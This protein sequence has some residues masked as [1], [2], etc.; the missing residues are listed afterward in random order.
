[1]D[2]PAS[3]A[4]P[5]RWCLLLRCL[6]AACGAGAGSPAGVGCA[7][8]VRRVAWV[9]ACPLALAAALPGRC[10]RRGYWPA[11]A[12]SCAAWALRVARVLA[13]LLAWAA[14]P[15]CA[16]W[17]G[18]WPACWRWL[19]RCLGA[20]CGVGTGLLALAPALPGRC[21]WCGCWLLRCR[22]AAWQG[23]RCPGS[24]RCRAR[25]AAGSARHPR[26]GWA[27]PEKFF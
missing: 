15:G 24:G 13:R 18:C 20:A 12:G 10:V 7:A 25:A 6:G 21:V 5:A 3:C 11:C 17:R 14:L 1:M 23:C 9:L 26:R 22:G 16:A 4:V 2:V 19:L 8:G 27:I